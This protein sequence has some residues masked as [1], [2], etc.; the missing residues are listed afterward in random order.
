MMKCNAE[1]VHGV[2]HKARTAL[3][4]TYAL[5]NF[6]TTLSLRKFKLRQ[7]YEIIDD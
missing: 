1:R 2:L 4:G 5:I 6:E 7:T 3:L